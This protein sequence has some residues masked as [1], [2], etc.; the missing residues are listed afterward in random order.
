V[1][2]ISIT[3]NTRQLNQALPGMYVDKI[4]FG[5]PPKEA[6]DHRKIYA[7]C[8]SIAMSAQRRGWS[9]AAFIN[10]VARDRSCL[11]LQLSTQR[12]GRRRSSASAYRVLH[13][14]WDTAEANLRN[15][16][17]RTPEDIYDDAVDR[18]VQWADRLTDGV[19]GLTES[20]CAVMSYV[21]GETQRRGMLR[22]TCP[23]RDVAEFAKIPHRTAARILKTLTRKGLLIKHYSGRG[24][25]SATGKAAIY[26]LA[27]PGR[28]GR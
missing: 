15:V 19:D 17:M 2:D 26:E 11:W 14:A 5:L 7:T 6:G 8:I 18:A 12:D 22:V 20:H 21:V 27:D 4:L 9:E 16:G 25:P 13:K 28:C 23:G 10:E 3:G 1:S 24:G